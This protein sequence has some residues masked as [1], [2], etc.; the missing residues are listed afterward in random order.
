ML[1]IVK[2]AAR[3]KSD[4]IK[5]HAGP[6][7]ITHYINTMKNITKIVKSISDCSENTKVLLYGIINRDDGNHNDKI[8]EMNNRMASYSKGQGL[9]FINNNN[10]NNNKNT[11]TNNDDDNDNNNNNNNNKLLNEI[12]RNPE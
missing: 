5:I 7:D 10:N 4:A 9:I 2:P 3:C 11:T 12:M 8:S 1:Y 6:N